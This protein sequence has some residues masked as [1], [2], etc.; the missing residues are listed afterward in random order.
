MITDV[1]HFEE[2]GEQKKH[3]SLQGFPFL[4]HITYNQPF[5]TLQ[6]HG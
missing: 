5:F 1:T 2:L 6:L 4:R 3:F